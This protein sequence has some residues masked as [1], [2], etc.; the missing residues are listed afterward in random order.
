MP[1]KTLKKNS[2]LSKESHAL[3]AFSDPI[4]FSRTRF[5]IAEGDTA[6]E[7]QVYSTNLNVAELEQ[8]FVIYEDL[9]NVQD[10]PISK[11]IQRELDRERTTQICDDYLLGNGG[12]RY[13]PPLTAV[14]IP[15]NHVHLPAECYKSPSEAEASA[16]KTK[17]LA[18]TPGLEEAQVCQVTGGFA[19]LVGEP[20]DDTGF[21]IWDK[22]SLVAVVI[23]GQ[24]RYQALKKAQEKNKT[25]AH[26]NVTVNL[27]D[28]SKISLN[29]GE[30]PTEIARNLFITINSTPK[31]VDEARLVLMDDRD[32]TSTFTQVLVD[33]SEVD[34]IPAVRPELVDWRCDGGKHDSLLSLTG[35]L[36]LRGVVSKALFNNLSISSLEDRSSRRKVTQWV[37]QLDLWI[38]PDEEIANDCGTEETINHRLELAKANSTELEDD[39]APFLFSYSTPAAKVIRSIFKDRYLLVF[40]LIY[41]D[42][43]PYRTFQATAKKHRAFEKNGKLHL[44]LRAFRSKR[45][46]LIQN[47][48]TESLVARYRADL[49]ELTENQILFTVMGQKALFAALFYLYLSEADTENPQELVSLTQSF[50]DK[51]N[52]D[53]DILQPSKSFDENFFSLRYK[54]SLRGFP[55]E[56][57]FCREFWKGI[58][59]GLNGDL[60][61]SN[62]AVDLLK[63]VLCDVLAFDPDEGGKFAFKNF[64]TIAA[65]HKKIICKVNTE[66]ED[67]EAQ[68]IAET[69]V[70]IKQ[71]ALDKLLS[72]AAANAT[73]KA[74]VDD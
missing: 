8:N 72:K 61:Y 74:I 48:E 65:R 9:K 53:F 7:I 46:E 36:T 59:V 52:S 50:I 71:A 56:A 32:A 39:E 55:K 68:K 27:I 49:K 69:A 41:S 38:R 13:F 30:S 14:L 12:I 67:D 11:L 54:P 35:V 29:T 15:T 64:S 16:I 37:K 2:G 18:N 45:D 5:G 3:F 73:K 31:E 58:I 51:F 21:L 22:Q 34:I 70:K 6:P 60:D 23:D 57:E 47:K 43:Q 62:A 1:A 28:L 33:D 24:H 63:S 26:C 4:A 66:M 10:W 17:V 40:R 25:F 19:E 44:Y 42:I 20:G